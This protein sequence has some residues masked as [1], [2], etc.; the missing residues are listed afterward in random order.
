MSGVIQYFAM[1]RLAGNIIMFLTILAGLWGFQ[2]LNFQLFPTFTF[3]SINISTN[4]DN[5]S[6]E[7]VQEAITIPLESALLALPEVRGTRSN[8]REGNASINVTLAE[9]LTIDDVQTVLNDT[10]EGVSLPAEASEPRIRQRAFRET[11]GS[12]L[13]Y[14]DVPVSQLSDLARGYA[15][16]L[17]AEGLAEVSIDGTVNETMTIRVPS[18]QLLALDLTLNELAQII[19]DQNINAPSGTL[20]ADGQTLLL[21][22]QGQ[23]RL[24]TDLARMPIRQSADGGALTLGDIAQFESEVSRTQDYY[25][26]GLPAVRLNLSRQEDD[27]S[28]AIARTMT[29]WVADA[30]QRLPEGVSLH[31]YRESWQTLATR[32]NMVV[33]NGLLGM[34]LVITVLFIFLNS[35]LAF[36]VAA[37]IPISFMA[38]FL[39]MGLNNITVNI[40]SLFGFMIALG[41]IVDDAIVV[42]EDTQAQR[43]AG[44]SSGNAAVKAARRMFP[45]VLASSLTTIAAFLPLTLVGGRF[46]SLMVD[47]PLVVVCTIVASLIECFIILP[48]HLH[49]SLKDSDGKK[50]SRFRVAVD[51]QV[52]RF[53]ER[54]FRPTVTFCV[55]H[56]LITVSAMVAAVMLSA[57]LI[58]GGKVPWTPFPDIEGSSLNARVSFTPDS[59]PDDVADYLAILENAL[60]A[61]ERELDYDFVDTAVTQINRNSLSGR[62]DVEMRADPDRPFSTNEILNVWREQMPI[63]DGLSNLSFTRTWGGLGNADITVQL[64][65]DEVERLKSASL[66]L[67]D[68]MAEMGGL[69]DIEDDLPYG[70]EQLSFRLSAQGQAQGLSLS[71]V[72]RHVSNQLQGVNVQNFIV[73]GETVPMRLELPESETRNF[74]AWETLPYPLSGGGWAPLGELLDARYQQG[75][76]RL[77]RTDGTMDIQVV[78]SAVDSGEINALLAELEQ[79]VLPTMTA[80]TGIS[81]NLAGDRTEEEETA[82]AM[83]IALATALIGMYLILAWVFSAWTWPL[84]VLITIPFGLT[85]AIFGHWV[86]DLQLSFLSLFGLFGLSGIVVNDSIVLVTFYRRLRDEGLSI[87]AAVVEA[88]CQRLRA[89]FLTSVTTIA[90]L[91]PILFDTSIDADF[92]RPLAAGIVFGLMFSTLLILLLVP[93]LLLWLERLNHWMTHRK[94][95]DHEVAP[96]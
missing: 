2:Q 1:H 4:W 96:F 18:E 86:L 79:S 67:Q 9:G 37:G 93:T 17:R 16:E 66:A 53:R 46:G 38:T 64:S 52:D 70:T 47:I 83:L 84:V 58:Q 25:Y 39:F 77:Q 3:S 51:T 61:A 42:A 91:S 19:R 59:Q 88:A 94:R 5:A 11:V 28:L 14:G 71:D 45:P 7:D 43:A 90:G 62:I 33:E 82:T 56:G 35:R 55:Q 22:A 21:R 54:I 6:A 72:S 15:S 30:E 12:I 41:I 87:E 92:L 34:V 89:V 65:G 31:T 75:I 50:P 76:D 32:L 60:A 26:Q 78:A 49:H 44:E 85:G 29:N 27:N 95:P 63:V 23:S 68:R 80:E 13:V 24:L 81:M 69:V 73:R 20:E 36:W 48:A 8:S 74:R 10:V 57:G 40:I